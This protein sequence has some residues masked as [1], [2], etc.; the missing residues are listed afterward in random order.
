MNSQLDKVFAF[1]AQLSA[2][3]FLL[4]IV[5]VAAFYYFSPLYDSGAQMLLNIS[6]VQGDLVKE[7]EKE[8]ETDQVLKEKENVEAL[9]S[10]LDSQIQ[11]ASL[12]LPRDLPESQ[13]AKEIDLIA[14]ASG[15]KISK[16]E[17]GLPKSDNIVEVLPLT[18]RGQGTYSEVTLFFYY[19]SSLKRI[20]RVS[21]FNLEPIINKKVGPG[22][23]GDLTFSAEVIS[24][25]YLGETSND[26]NP[27]KG[28]P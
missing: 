12:Q 14:K 26:K 22:Y 5:G 23:T 28:R 10:D 8:K 18:V 21:T 13:I 11:N 4:L 27:A 17:N 20:T 6:K 1:L 25:R 7:K 15:L 16:R 19:I 9:N 3:R 2:Q 24:Y